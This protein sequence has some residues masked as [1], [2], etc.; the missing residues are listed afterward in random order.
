MIILLN[1]FFAFM[2]VFFGFGAVADCIQE[3]RNNYTKICI[4]YIIAIIIVNLF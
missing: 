2:A 3:N 4:A 1:I